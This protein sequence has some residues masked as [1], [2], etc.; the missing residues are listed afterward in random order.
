MGKNKVKLIYLWFFR[1]NILGRF[2]IFNILIPWST[3][4]E[5]N[6]KDRDIGITFSTRVTRSVAYDWQATCQVPCYQYFNN[7]KGFTWR[8][9]GITG[10][11]FIYLYAGITETEVS[12]RN[13]VYFSRVTFKTPYLV[14]CKC[15][16]KYNIYSFNLLKFYTYLYVSARLK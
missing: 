3:T 13:E 14:F 4:H 16:N 5:I 1:L 2:Q 11:Q 15:K 6:Y 12:S 9:E 7:F 8:D 10:F